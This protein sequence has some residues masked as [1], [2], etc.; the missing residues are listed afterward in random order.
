MSRCL[1][2]PEGTSPATEPPPCEC[3]HETFERQVRE[4]PEAIAV[5]C[6]SEQL[7]YAVLNRQANQLAN[8]LKQLGVGPGAM[9]A[10]YLERTPKMVVAIL[11]VLKAGGAYVPIDLAYPSERLLFMLSDTQAPVVITQETLRAALPPQVPRVL[12]VDG[13]WGKVATESPENPPRSASSDDPAYVIYTSGS[14]GKP[15]GVL[16]THHN[17]VRLLKSTAHWY[18]FNASDVWPLFHSYAFDVSV[19]EL[20]GSL[21]HGGR[22]VIVP[23]LV[24]RTPHE[25]YEL[26]AKE[27]V[28]VLNQT[29]SA[30]RQL[31][32]A[33]ETA[34]LKR[35]LSLRYVI[36]AGEALELQS[37]KPWFDRHGDQKPKVVNM[38]G[39]TET[40]VHST[41][42][43][44]RQEDL[45]SGVG[46]VIGVPIPDLSLYL[47]DED[48]KP[49]P[50]GVP[51]E[52]CVGGAGVAR[53]YL[54]RPELTSKRFLPDPFAAEPDARL[55]RSGDLAQVNNKGELEYL[56]RMDH[57]V[58]IRGFR[59]ELGEIESALN[60][61]AAIRESV[62]LARD[63][64]G[65]GKRLV[66]YA[67][68]AQTAPTVTELREC[69]RTKLPEYMLPAVFVFLPKLPLTT[70]GKVDRRALP[71]PDGARPAL[72]DEFVPPRNST[73]ETLTQ[74]W[75]EAL[76]VQKV[77][78]HD[79]L[80]E[81]G[82]DSIRSITILSKAQQKG[83]RRSLEQ[84]FRYPTVAGLAACEEPEQS[85]VPT[86]PTTPFS[87]IK[88]QDRA[89]LAPDAQDA[90][91]ITKLQLGMFYCNELD[92]ASAMYHDV[93]SYRIQAAF[94]GA[95]LQ[96]A[97]A[98]L[99]RRH[100]LLRTSFHL[101]GFSEPL[102]VVH[103][104][105]Q[106]PFTI[107]DLREFTAAEQDRALLNWIETEKRRPFE[108]STAPLFRFHAQLRSDQ[109]F[110]LIL[111]FH[112]SCLDGWSLAAV[113]TEV[114][115][116]YA[117][118]RQ[119]LLRAI[120]P[121][122]VTYRDFVALEQRAVESDSTR[123]FWRTQLEGATPQLVPRWPESLRAGGH[124][125]MRGPELFVEERV[126]LG[127]KALAQTAG[128]PLK[129][130]LLAAHQRVMA[131]MCGTSDVVSGLICNG[132]PETVDGE[133]LIGLFLNTL[134]LRQQLDG[135]TWLELVKQTFA[136]EQHLM[137]HRRFP[138]AELHKLTNGQKL[139]ETAFDFVHFHV[140]KSLQ[141]CREIDLA[142]GHYF[143]ANNLT[144]YTTFM[145]DVN[146]TRLEL[147]IDY[148]PNALCRQ[149]V[150]E[151]SAYYLK[152]L[153][154][155]AKEPHSHYETAALLSDSETHRMLIEWNKT[156]ESFPEEKGIP[157][158]FV[159]RA[160]EKPDAIALVC[161]AERW[162]YRELAQRVEGLAARLRE[163]NLGPGALA[164]LCVERSPQMVVAL[165]AILKTGAGY[166]PLDPSYP[167]E[168]LA[169]MLSDAKVDLLLTQQSLAAN[170]VET[171]APVLFLD[172]RN[173]LEDENLPHLP[174]PA[175]MTNR[176]G[177]LAYVIYTSG[178]TGKPKGVQV[179]HRSVVNLV[180]AIARKTGF[181][182]SDNL[183]AV[184][185]ISFDIAGLELYLPLIMGG[186][187]T[188]AT[189]E[190]AGDGTQ[191]AALMESCGATV[192]QGTPA[193]WRL[194]IEAGWT[195][196][197]S[198]TAFCGGEAL[199]ANLAEALLSRTKTVWNLYGPTETT[200]WSTASR[201]ETGRPITIGRPL[202]NTQVYILD[203]HLRPMPVGAVGELYIGGNGLAPGYLNQPEL[204]REKFLPNPFAHASTTTAPDMNPAENKASADARIYRTG[205]LAR[206]CIGGEIECLGRVDHQVKI[207][208]FRIELGEVETALRQHKGIADALV[209]A[210]ADALGEK[211]LVG[212]IISKNGPPSHVELREFVKSRLPAYMVP[213]QFVLLKQFPLTPNGKVDLRQLPAPEGSPTATQNYQ[214][215]R[216]Q[217][218]QVVQNIWEEVLML[219]KVGIDDHFFEL[220]GDSLSATRVFARINRA[221]DLD[222]SLREILE[223]PT[224]RA[225]AELIGDTSK[226]TRSVP[227][228]I[229]RQPRG[230]RAA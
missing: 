16:V 168:R 78:I 224:I 198:L 212:Y 190:Q 148:D 176:D 172:E 96:E 123:G 55:Y 145:L 132:R 69:L 4:T 56:G 101:A 77:G 126:F 41:Y 155:M 7:S 30:F 225:L 50:A 226:G 181:T 208:G 62:V 103:R 122:Q 75:S 133:K 57:Q 200:I 37:L 83:L 84:I 63:E 19:W 93:F 143:E 196:T 29:P 109:S 186:T 111:S 189:R 204:T 14:T 138:L 144:T 210:R 217:P 68:P 66:A 141:G 24:T 20:W 121:P 128:V 215:P 5:S 113:I 158:L 45:T 114:L 34:E 107:E 129:T 139:F 38:Y 70:N 17:V 177:G 214:A 27:K 175:T 191:L 142:E 137:P 174:A 206:Y 205:D 99:A 22:L 156:V 120:E 76:G 130:V 203:K 35:D 195:G 131:L 197:K 199:Q 86:T 192:M 28:T 213:A 60:R 207:R 183:L 53:G 73:E 187:L 188:L 52:I 146:S 179:L 164:G 140:Y 11:A 136:A 222:L 46:S 170:L 67:V 125:Q 171:K 32:W 88:S 58:K 151:M 160:Q 51:G 218:E 65:G 95:K 89:R 228:T 152:A 49:V 21:F 165:L 182:R 39:I 124:E 10:L 94:D 180:T 202:A 219:K 116:E 36:C 162:S 117:A 90:Y 118:L 3:I 106:V 230:L 6:G 79:N 134:P 184:T 18:G 71:D 23:Y 82:G 54:N 157:D 105:I 44:I 221:F 149:Q 8:Y 135:G 104:N 98:Q 2:T 216:N 42:R 92:P 209:T 147:H 220:G 115:Q 91:P 163:F 81:L 25:F 43:V 97:I 161:G 64:A 127:L 9:V 13:D 40:T 48:L 223:R 154:A 59:V 33:E 201:I 31:I 100:P 15:K 119:G 72:N 193:T 85:S 61:H 194:L 211:K 227:T 229:P 166:V 12:C 150:E 87:L 173:P 108:R 167:K 153:D 47:V 110:Q 112:H 185:T 80:F 178:S 169:F 1:T 74:I 102:Q 159:E 26:I